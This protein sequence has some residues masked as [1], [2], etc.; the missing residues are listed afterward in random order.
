M[1]NEN[2]LHL[3]SARVQC[4]GWSYE[5]G[6]LRTDGQG[7]WSEKAFDR[8]DF[9]YFAANTHPDA[10][11]HELDLISNWYV[12]GWFVDDY[13]PQTFDPGNSD[14]GEAK[15]Y[16]ARLLSFMPK[17]L[18]TPTPEAENPAE[19][20]LANLWTRTAPTMSQGWR[21]RF[22]EHIQVM[23]DASLRELFNTDKN[24]E[25]ILD[26]VEFITQRRKLS[27]MSWAA[28]LVEHSLAAEIP[29]EIYD[30]RPIRV[31]N[32]TY[33]DR[34]ALWNDIISYNK[35]ID[36]GKVNN[37]V[38]VVQHFLNTD[39]QKAVNLVND[40]ATSRLYQFENT[41]IV[42]LYPAMDERRLDGAAR[43]KVL[44]YVKALQDWMAGEL[45]WALR[46]GG[47][48][49][50]AES[51]KESPLGGPKGLGTAAARVGLSPAAMGLRIRTYNHIP[52]QTVGAIT[53]PEFYM[54]FPTELH[55]NLEEGRRT[56]KAWAYEMGMIGVSGVSFW[57]EQR[58][59]AVDSALQVALMYPQ[60]AN[61]VYDLIVKL[62]VWGFYLD[63]Y[64]EERYL[65]TRDLVGGKAFFARL[66]ALIS[67]D[68]VPITMLVDPCERGL[69]DIM[70]RMSAD[71][72]AEEKQR[73]RC[74]FKE[75]F[76]AWTRQLDHQ[77]Q[78]R[79]PD[80]IDYLELRQKTFG[81]DL[82]IHF[83]QND[84]ILSALYQTT[85][86]QSLQSV[87]SDVIGLTNDI[88]SYQKEIEH[89]GI[90]INGVLVTQH[91]LDCDLAKAVEVVNNLITARV[92]EFE[93]V[94]ANEL[95]FLCDELQLDESN[96][97][98]LFGYVKNLQFMMS[99]VL[100]WHLITSYYKESEFKRD[101]SPRNLFNVPTTL[102]PSVTRISSLFNRTIGIS[103]PETGSSSVQTSEPSLEPIVQ[104]LLRGPNGL[105][106]SATEIGS[107]GVPTPATD[108]EPMAPELVSSLTKLGPA[109]MQIRSLLGQ[110]D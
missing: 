36:D 87:A 68:S 3:Q 102:S 72:S 74:D 18:N 6:I 44:R 98:K 58:F 71:M 21:Q 2:P 95:P 78:N 29:P 55:P 40:L 31:L 88:I 83:N 46:P 24:K 80:P 110:Q 77:V 60:A 38:V 33:A 41:L 14:L 85:P 45:E 103:A 104:N 99:G 51:K 93:Y 28:D 73:L 94:V 19:Y 20:A 89:E 32:D 92:R 23:A 35:D 4:K 10:P 105:G 25:R 63:G 86:L 97:A 59:D 108:A 79:I 96:R 57:D 5:V 64:F 26:P 37:C 17:D 91:F 30:T 84:K 56:S 69:L 52:F 101:P 11:P 61:A 54:P 1:E 8:M 48:Y 76:A 15:A 90:L 106:T 16:L 70:Q 43:Q 82:L 62:V 50:P 34:G 22:V 75:V 66:L 81:F 47:R 39:L 9:A 65:S 107:S 49:L 109:T 53:P 12:W 13:F 42:E 7:V 27:G 67:S 100:K